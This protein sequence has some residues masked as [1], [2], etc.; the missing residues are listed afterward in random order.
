MPNGFKL[1]T[2]W[3]TATRLK[4]IAATTGLLD[5][6]AIDLEGITASRSTFG[7]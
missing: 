4:N 5:V 1:G 6:D 7:L 2:K 3:N